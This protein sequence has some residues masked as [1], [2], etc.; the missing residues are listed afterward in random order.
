MQLYS[1]HKGC[2]A[3]TGAS[4][5][6]C[7]LVDGYN[8]PG[9]LPGIVSKA[10]PTFRGIVYQLGM[11]SLLGGEGENSPSDGTS[12][13]LDLVLCAGVVVFL[14]MTGYWWG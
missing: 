6:R 14:L 4:H 7:H 9:I 1:H 13:L 8:S 3:E 10:K 11:D 2:T 12:I 5:G